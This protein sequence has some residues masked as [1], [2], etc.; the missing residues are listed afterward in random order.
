MKKF[1]HILFISLWSVLGLILLLCLGFVNKEQDQLLCKSMDIKVNQDNDLYFLDNID[2]AQLIKSRNK[3]IDQPK[4]TVNIPDIEKA[5]NSHPNIA[6]AEVSITI[7]GK[8]K[9]QVKQRKPILRIFNVSDES[10]YMDDDGMLMPLSEKYTAKVLIANG[11]IAESYAKNYKRTMQSI[12]KDS[13]VKARTM[14]DELYAM[15]SFIDANDF[16]RAQIQQIYINDN[17]DMEVVP[18]VGD[19]RIIFGDTTA[20][21]EKFKKLLIFYRQGLNTTGWWNKYSVINL[22]FK[23]QIVCTKK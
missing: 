11:K 16:W 18:I 3:I 12:S 6:N 4:A 13:A 21:E 8:L 23:N 10:Y 15:A 19:Q 5:L 14:F 22:K 9:V 20:M 2:V 17:L 1:K 7:D